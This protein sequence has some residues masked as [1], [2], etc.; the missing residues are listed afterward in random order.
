MSGA[1]RRYGAAGQSPGLY[2]GGE[3]SM[4]LTTRAAR[5]GV[6]AAPM[7]A[8]PI[9]VPTAALATSGRP[10][11]PASTVAPKCTTAALTAW[12]PRLGSGYAGGAVYELEIFNISDRA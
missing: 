9:L 3:M 7:L 6:A 8:P 2:L 12:M 11:A 5:R 1:C 4:N 10:A